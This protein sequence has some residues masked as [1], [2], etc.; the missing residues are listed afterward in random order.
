MFMTIFLT[1][2]AASRFVGL[3]IV[4]ETVRGIRLERNA[5]SV[6]WQTATRPSKTTASS[7]TFTRSRWWARTG[8]STSSA[9]RRLTRPRCLPLS[10]TPIAAAASRSRRSS[11]TRCTGSFTCPTPTC[12]SPG[13]CPTAASPRCLTSCRWR[14]PA[15]HTTSCVARRRSAARSV[16][17]CAAIRASTTPA[18]RTRWSGAATRKSCSSAAPARASWRCGCARRSRCSS[19]RERPWPSS[20]SAPTSRRGSSSRW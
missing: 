19:R 11:T 8:R 5:F 7:A 16:S 6:C 13:S 15:S 17:P 14:T 18:P 1:S 9:S 10:S 12:C 2:V 4:F 3:L 20:R